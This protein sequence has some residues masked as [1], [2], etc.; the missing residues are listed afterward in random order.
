MST[1]K[2]F[3]GKEL[4]IGDTVILVAPGYRHLCKATIIAFTPKQVRVEYSNTWNHGDEGY[5]QQIIQLP[6]QLV[7]IC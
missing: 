5:V 6:S 2:D 7:R 1:Y 3:L 4:A